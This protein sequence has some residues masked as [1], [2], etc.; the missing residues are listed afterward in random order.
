VKTSEC[1]GQVPIAPAL[2]VTPEDSDVRLTWNPI[3]TGSLGCPISPT[4]YLLWYSPTEPGPYYFL[5]YTT[6]TTYVHPG[7]VQF[8]PS[9]YYYGETYAGDP[10]L[11]QRL[12]RDRDLLFTREE[13]LR[14]LK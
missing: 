14:S 12:P 7:V 11:L 1:P 4:G 8:A 13:I 3:T 6:D 5:A 2:V 10:L 9:M